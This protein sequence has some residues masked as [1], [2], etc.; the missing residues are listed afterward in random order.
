M[1]RTLSA[2]AALLVATPAFAGTVTL[3]LSDTAPLTN[4]D[5]AAGRYQYSGGDILFNGQDIGDFF[6]TKRVIFG[7]TSANEFPVEIVLNISDRVVGSGNVT[8]KGVHSF[9]SGAQEGGVSAASPAFHVLDGGTYS[10]SSTTDALVID[11]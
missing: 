10:F 7:A 4:V 11:F 9:S 3:T 2:A 8:L 5:D 6:M 1:I